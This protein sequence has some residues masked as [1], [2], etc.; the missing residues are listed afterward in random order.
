M[1]INVDLLQAPLVQ[2]KSC[3]IL[4]SEVRNAIWVANESYPCFKDYLK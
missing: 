3:M 1:E 2:Y 4:L